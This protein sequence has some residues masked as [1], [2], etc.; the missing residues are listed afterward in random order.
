[1]SSTILIALQVLII[2][3][4]SNLSMELFFYKHFTVNETE[5]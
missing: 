3:P 2:Q 4:Y 5:L 1:M